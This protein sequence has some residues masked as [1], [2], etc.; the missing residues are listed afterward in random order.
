M[1]TLLHSFVGS[2]SARVMPER[3]VKTRLIVL[4]NDSSL[5][6][7]DARQHAQAQRL[8]KNR[9]FGDRLILQRAE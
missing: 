3:K 8:A 5:K 1:A 2:T 7:H 6:P 4:V 9:E